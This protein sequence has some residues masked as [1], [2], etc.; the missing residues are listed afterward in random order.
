MGMMKLVRNAGDAAI[1]R[2]TWGGSQN[3]LG[4]RWVERVVDSSPGPLRKRL[5]L[6][7]LSLSPHYFYDSDRLEEDARNRRSRQLIADRL[8]IPQV[9]GQ[10]HVLDYGCGPGYL[11]A[12]VAD[13]VARVD[14]V[15]ISRGVLACARVINPRPNIAYQALAQFQ[16]ERGPARV[17]MAYSFAVVQHL[18]TSALSQMLD[19]LAAAV[20]P[21]GLLMLHFA[22]TEGDWRTEQQWERDTSLTGRAKLRYGLNCF[23]RSAAEMTAMVG[24]RGFTDVTVSP[25][26]E[27]LDNLNDDVREQHLLTARR[28]LWSPAG[29]I[30]RR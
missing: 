28:S 19:L 15:D 10:S 9:T 4:A 11:A 17:D 18:R 7:F 5:A 23:G 20:R 14:A 8:I 21:E 3:F 25:L 24:E 16:A 13:K 12:A 26:S 1:S 30:C 29:E 27:S 6:H 2:A 22:Q